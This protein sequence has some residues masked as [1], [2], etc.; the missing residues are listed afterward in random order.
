MFCCFQVL[1]EIFEC[2][3]RFGFDFWGFVSSFGLDMV[4]SCV[5]LGWLHYYSNNLFPVISDSKRNKKEEEEKAIWKPND[6]Q[7]SA[8]TNVFI[9]ITF[10]FP[11]V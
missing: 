5:E 6:Q 4:M 9:L 2:Q 7:T 1:C 8:M 10:R 3:M 11:D